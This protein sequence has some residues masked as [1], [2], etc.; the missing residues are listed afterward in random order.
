MGHL[1]FVLP[2]QGEFCIFQGDKLS[3]E[4]LYLILVSIGITMGLRYRLDIIK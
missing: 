1:L 3:V 4:G 2:A